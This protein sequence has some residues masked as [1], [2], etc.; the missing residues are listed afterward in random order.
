MSERKSKRKLRI[1]IKFQNPEF[2]NNI[3]IK[4]PYLLRFHQEIRN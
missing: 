2:F 1:L 3:F 4:Q